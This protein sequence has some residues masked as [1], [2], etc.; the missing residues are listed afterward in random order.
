MKIPQLLSRYVSFVSQ[1][2]KLIVD[3][4]LHLVD[5]LIWLLAT[6]Y[7][8]WVWSLCCGARGGGGVENTNVVAVDNGVD[9]LVVLENVKRNLVDA[10]DEAA[11][12]GGGM[13]T[14]AT[15]VEK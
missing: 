1:V 15:K 3:C 14:K 6:S 10:F 9:E 12:A 4:L 2:K 5:C 11:T 13:F 8:P 7:L